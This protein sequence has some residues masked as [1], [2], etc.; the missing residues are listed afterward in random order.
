[1]RQVIENEMIKGH[2]VT[3][4]MN[5][6]AINQPVKITLPAASETTSS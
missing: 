1:M 4:T 3:T 6:T 2:V 5:V